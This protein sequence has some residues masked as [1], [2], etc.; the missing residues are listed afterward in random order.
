MPLYHESDERK[1]EEELLKSGKIVN[2]S[3]KFSEPC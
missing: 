2:F 3:I 1:W